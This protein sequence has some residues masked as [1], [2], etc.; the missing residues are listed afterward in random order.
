MKIVK[1]KEANPSVL[2]LDGRLDANT[3]KDLERFLK[4]VLD[5]EQFDVLIDCEDLSYISSA[6]LRVLLSTA[7]ECSKKF[8]K[9]AL[10]TLSPHIRQI[11]EISGFVDI[12]P[13]FESRNEAL[14]AL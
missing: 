1:V 3:A 6:G 11:F 13:V 10:C 12:F 9:V 7:S 14:K 2:A 4:E 8:G 5:Q